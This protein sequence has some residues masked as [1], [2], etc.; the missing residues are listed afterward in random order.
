LAVA[1]KTRG[2]FLLHDNNSVVF[3]DPIDKARTEY[4]VHLA[5][6]DNPNGVV[7]SVQKFRQQIFG[8][9]GLKR[10]YG[11]SDDPQV[12]RMLRIAGL[13]VLKSDKPKFAWM[14]EE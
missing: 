12:Q 14:A 3:L 2:A 10:I 4:A 8:T 9:P 5:T 6:T 1:E 7:R 11:T 13:N